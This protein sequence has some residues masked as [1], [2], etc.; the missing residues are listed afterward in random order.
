MYRVFVQCCITFSSSKHVM[1]CFFSIVGS[2]GMPVCPSHR[3]FEHHKN[4]STINVIDNVSASS[5]SKSSSLSQRHHCLPLHQ[6]TRPDRDPNIRPSD[7]HHGQSMP[8][9]WLVAFACRTSCRYFLGLV[10]FHT[11]NISVCFFS[12]ELTF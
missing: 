5:S 6:A 3:P 7:H 10:H 2:V 8:N 9:V 12:L 11:F 1:G 4:L